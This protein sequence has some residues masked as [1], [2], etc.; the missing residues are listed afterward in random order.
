MLATL[1]TILTITPFRDVRYS[2]KKT[3]P[4]LKFSSNYKVY[5]VVY[6]IY[7]YIYIFSLI[8]L[9]MNNNILRH[10]IIPTHSK[11]G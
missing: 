6:F 10:R 9:N 3:N 7:K 5:Q 11:R 8:E 2:K 1:A 4:T